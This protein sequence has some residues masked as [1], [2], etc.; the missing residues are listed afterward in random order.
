MIDLVRL[1][2]FEQSYPSELSGGMQQRVAIARALM[3]NP[4]ILLMDEPFGALDEITRELMNEELVR[5]WQSPQT[6][7]A[8]V[9][10]V[11]HSIREAVQLSDRIFLLAARPARLMEIVDIPVPRPRALEDVSSCV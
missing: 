8:T 7:L 2:G 9:V 4:T 1:S 3:S 11:T 5:I 6:R 10:M